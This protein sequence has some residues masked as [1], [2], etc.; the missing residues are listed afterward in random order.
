MGRA[1]RITTKASELLAAGLDRASALEVAISKVAATPADRAFARRLWDRMAPT[2]YQ[3]EC[4]ARTAAFDR[5]QV[6][7]IERAV[8][9]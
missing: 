3:V 6:E 2:A 9:R 4:R 7:R 5:A 8:A 1:T